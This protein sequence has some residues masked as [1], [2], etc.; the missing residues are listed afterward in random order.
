[1]RAPIEGEDLLSGSTTGIINIGNAGNRKKVSGGGCADAN[2]TS[3]GNEKKR[4]N[5]KKQEQ[6]N[7]GSHISHFHQN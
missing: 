5:Y 1:M 6:N 3:L 4:N 7:S 2:I